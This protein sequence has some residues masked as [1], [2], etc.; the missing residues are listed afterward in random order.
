MICR[1]DTAE[2]VLKHCSASRANGGKLRIA[3]YVGCVL[4]AS[5]TFIAARAIDTNRQTISRVRV[6]RN[7]RHNE[8]GRQIGKMLLEQFIKIAASLQD[9][10]STRLNSSYV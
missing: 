4:P 7:L 2:T 10:K 6:Q 3:A 9:R 8:P 5:L 1:L